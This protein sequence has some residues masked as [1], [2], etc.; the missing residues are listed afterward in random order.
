LSG[1]FPAREENRLAS[2]LN[3]IQSFRLFRWHMVVLEI[4]LAE[5]DMKKMIF[6]ER[7]SSQ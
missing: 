6:S 5:I 3:R 1:C 2:E 7:T 4:S